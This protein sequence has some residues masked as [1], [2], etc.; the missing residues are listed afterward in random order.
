[1]F[2]R[3]FRLLGHSE[4]T[5]IVSP[6]IGPTSNQ[7]KGTGRGISLVVALELNYEIGMFFVNGKSLEPIVNQSFR[8]QV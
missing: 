2:L 5:I 1:M 7:T 3:N 6:V 4:Y 8:F